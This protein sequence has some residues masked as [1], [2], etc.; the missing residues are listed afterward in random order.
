M[1]QYNPNVG[2][3]G[4][5]V[6][7]SKDRAWFWWWRVINNLSSA[8]SKISGGGKPGYELSKRLSL[9]TNSISL[10]SPWGKSKDV[11]ALGTVFELEDDVV[12]R[13]LLILTG[14]FSVSPTGTS[15][16]SISEADS[17]SIAGSAFDVVVVESSL[18]S[19]GGT[20]LAERKRF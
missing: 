12:E 7:E 15:E 5:L 9:G 1:G 20:A 17:G 3:M 2:S 16:M 14:P 19:S 6:D 8:S 13:A 10:S 18:G 4:L 11:E